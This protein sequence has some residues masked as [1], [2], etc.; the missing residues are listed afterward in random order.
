MA[1][2]PFMTQAF[3]SHFESHKEEA[4]KAITDKL[5]EVLQD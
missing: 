3:E 4:L 1:K 2:K 5:K